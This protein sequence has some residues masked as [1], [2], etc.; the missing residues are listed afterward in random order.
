LLRGWGDAASE[1]QASQTLA[2]I[3]AK[4]IDSG[5]LRRRLAKLLAGKVAPGALS[6]VNVSAQP[7]QD[8]DLLTITT[9]SRNPQRAT[10]V[11]T[12]T[13]SALAAFIDKSGSKSEQIS[14][15]NT[16]EGS[17]VSKHLA[18][19]VALALILGLIF[20]GALALVLELVRDRLPEPDELGR[21][22]GHPVLATIPSLRLHGVAPIESAGSS[23]EA[24]LAL[25]TLGDEAASPQGS[26]RLGS[27]P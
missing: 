2:Q 7:V 6:E 17:A 10:I 3:Y 15:V 13:P 21:T 24:A 20:N 26:S 14:T 23:T 9:R 18:L 8:L 12:A 1:L 19:N 27:E 25:D 22:V 4:I 11:A 16:T 5:A